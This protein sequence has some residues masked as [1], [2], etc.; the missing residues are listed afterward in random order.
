MACSEPWITLGRGVD[1]CLAR[2]RSTAHALLVAR[3]RGQPCGFVIL[4]PTGVAGSPYIAAIATDAAV[5]GQGVGTALLT[6]AEQYDPAAR[7]IFLCCSSFNI[8]A[9]RLYE[10]LGFEPVGSRPGYYDDPPETG[11]VMRI[12]S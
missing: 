3:Q 5:R 1:D 8:R 2:C 10:R 12:F 4:H 9:R 7:H 6:F 11:I